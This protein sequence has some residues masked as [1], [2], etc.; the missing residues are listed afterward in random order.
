MS[1]FGLFTINQKILIMAKDPAFLFY[2]GDWLGGTIGMTLEE[3]GAY[4]EVLILQF[5]RGHMSEHMIQR[6]IGDNWQHIK[7]KF[8][9]D[10][11]GLFY[12]E[13]LEFEK[14]KRQNYTKSRSDNRLSKKDE[15]DEKEIK[16]KKTR[17]KKK[18]STSYDSHMLQHMENENENE[19]I[20]ANELS[21]YPFSENFIQVWNE[22]KQYKFEQHKFKFK[23]HLTEQKQFNLLVKLSGE[24][25]SYAAELVNLAIGKAWE[26]FHIPNDKKTKQN[27]PTDRDA[28]RFDYWNKLV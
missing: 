14:N 21:I 1:K 4:I 17:H 5:N 3:K 8:K 13:R 12:N 16:T 18:I 6:I 27:E 15:Q 22:W 9:Q 11:E 10:S 2:P 28:D 26:G 23:S 7:Q 20:N 19:N 24:N 25:E